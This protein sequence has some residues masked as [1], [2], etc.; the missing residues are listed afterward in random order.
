MGKLLIVNGSPRAPRSNSKKYAEHFKKYW[1]NDTEEYNVTVKQHTRICEKL[2]QYGDL[3][4]VFPLYADG[5][6]VTLMHF[7]KEVERHSIENKPTIHVLINCGFIEPEQ[8]EM[9][10]EMIRFFCKKNNYSYGATLCIGSGEAILTTPFVF[11]V[12][13]KIK[14][15]VKAIQKRHT[16]T[17]QVTMPLPKK[18][19]IKA[20]TKYWLNYGKKNKIGKNEMETMK[21]EGSTNPY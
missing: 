7:L 6:P 20:S 14:K 8:N 1:G 9:A 3:L 2:G 13:Q 10:V 19:F 17:M 4:L 21:I 18:L 15:L 11:L 16:D 5:L 12:N